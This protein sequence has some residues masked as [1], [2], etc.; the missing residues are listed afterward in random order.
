MSKVGV[1]ISLFKRLKRRI[2][3][4]RYV[5]VVIKMGK[6]LSFRNFKTVATTNKFKPKLIKSLGN[7]HYC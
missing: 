3:S 4:E 5:K 2:T 7:N 1:N 6:M